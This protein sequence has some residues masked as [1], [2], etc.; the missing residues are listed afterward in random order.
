[1]AR[2]T[3]PPRVSSNDGFGPSAVVAAD[4]L[5]A[6]IFGDGHDKI[7]ACIKYRAQ[8]EVDWREAPMAFVDNDRWG[9]RFPVHRN[10][11]YFYTI[12]AWRDQFESWRAEV[13]KKHDAGLDLGLELTEGRALLER[14]REQA[15][16]P[17][18]EALIALLDELDTQRDEE[19]ALLLVDA[20]EGP[21]PQTRFVLR[22]ALECRPRL[23]DDEAARG[24]FHPH[25]AHPVDVPVARLLDRRA[26]PGGHEPALAQVVEQVLFGERELRTHGTA[27]PRQIRPQVSLRAAET[28]PQVPGRSRG[29]EVRT[30]T[31]RRPRTGPGAW[32]SSGGP[33]RP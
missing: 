9:G 17:D 7:A 8:D 5:G 29:G 20:S 22:K 3:I 31:P 27:P 14:T 1:M 15:K 18:Q 21:L 23:L 32:A 2:S 6:D 28:L 12:E 13:M 33:R 24:V 16:G 10:C 25:P 30:L 19:G 4:G 26:R 11:R